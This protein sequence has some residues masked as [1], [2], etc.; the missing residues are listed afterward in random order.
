MRIRFLLLVLSG[1]VWTG[2]ACKTVDSYVLRGDLTVHQPLSLS[3]TGPLCSET[4]NPNPFLDYRMT[5]VFRHESGYEVGVPGYFAADGTAADTGANRGDQW[6]VHF[7]PQLPGEWT[8][9]VSLRVGPGVALEPDSSGRSAPGDGLKGLFQI[10]EAKGDVKPRGLLQYAG[11][12]YFRFAGDGKRFLKA[13]ADS[14]ENFLAYEE[15]DWEDPGRIQAVPA[16]PGEARPSRRHRYEPHVR[17]WRPGDPT[18]GEDGRGK[19]VIGAVNYLASQGVNSVYFL[20]MNIGGDGDDVWPYLTR[21]ERYRF[22]CSRLDQWERLFE[23]M[24]RLGVGL[25]VVLTET[26][27]ESL[28]EAEEGGEFAPSRKLYYREVIARFA[29]HSVLI[30]NIGEENGWDDKKEGEEVLPKNRGNTDRQRLLF[31]EFIRRLDPYDHPIV[32]HTLPGQWDRIYEPLLGSDVYE[33]AS[34]QVGNMEQVHEQTLRW[35]RR[36]AE[37]GRPWVVTLD[38]IG[39]HQLGVLPD[40]VDP[41]HDEVRHYALWGNLTAG[42]AGC[43]WYFGYEYPH[44]DLSLEDFRTRE[45]MWRQT[46]TAVEFFQDH[47]PFW[48]MSACDE[49][50]TGDGYCFGKEEDLWVVYRPGASRETRLRLPAGEFDVVWFD[51]RNGGELSPG[52]PAT[53]TGPGDLSLGTPPREEEKD[54]VAVIRK[55]Y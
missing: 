6:R 5:V 48:E 35:V 26:E 53:L 24:E 32:V 21:D 25:H 11:E 55:P 33:G 51:P 40:E 14:P 38:E 19:G 22:D 4:D 45:S 7:V 34:L 2:P 1:L 31:A 13:G 42:G 3:L 44:D 37:A 46:R 36:S 17:D 20:T 52:R 43:E 18:W 39:P 29:H 8:F 27:N 15:F 12:R 28:F 50:L 41:G 23:H 9:T 30:W 49:R 16:R 10:Q 54:W 47:L